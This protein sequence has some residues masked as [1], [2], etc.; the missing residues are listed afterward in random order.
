MLEPG[1]EQ[2]D[3]HAASLIA[4]FSVIANH[5]IVIH[6]LIPSIDSNRHAFCMIHNPCINGLYTCNNNNSNI[7]I[8]YRRTI[9]T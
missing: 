4:M 8:I 7:I 9:C 3:Q 2:H 1:R 6:T 5:L